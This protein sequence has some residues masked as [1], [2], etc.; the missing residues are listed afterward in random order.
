MPVRDKSRKGSTCRNVSSSGAA[1]GRVTGH[2]VSPVSVIVFCWGEWVSIACMLTQL[3][4]LILC[5]DVRLCP[6]RVYGYKINI[7]NAA[8]TLINCHFFHSSSKSD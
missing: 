5:V 7:S 6:S 3:F 4:R 8:H 2:G 1:S